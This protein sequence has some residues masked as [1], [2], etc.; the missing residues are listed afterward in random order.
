MKSVLIPLLACIAGLSCG[1]ACATVAAYEPFLLASP[2]FADNGKLDAK[3]AGDDKLNAN[4]VGDN[5]SP[6]LT[7]S[8]APPGTKSY[9]L[10]EIDPE[11]RAGL[12]VVHWVAYGIPV[13]VTALAEGE[14]SQPSDKLVGGRGTRG[15]ATYFGPCTGP[16]LTHHFVFTLIATD[17]DPKALKPGL[18]REELLAA[19]ASHV[20]GAA[21]IIGRYERP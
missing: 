12:S 7:W 13:S 5:V 4:C 15:H 21:G 9:A 16:G 1:G 6:P 14:G 19:L 3:Y 17:L 10:I 8:H 2:S 20:R 18:T 11:G